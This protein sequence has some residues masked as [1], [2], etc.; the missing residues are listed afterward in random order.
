MPRRI[1]VLEDDHFQRAALIEV[2]QERLARSG[3]VKV[4]EANS[5]SAAY[6]ELDRALRQRWFFDAYILDRIVPWSQEDVIPDR[7]ERVRAEGSQ[8]AGFR[9]AERI[10]EVRSQLARPGQPRRDPPIV[11]YTINDDEFSRS[12]HRPDDRCFT[13]IKREVDP[14]GVELERILTR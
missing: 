9:V 4:T 8:L 10:K 12:F 11:L 14:D 6:G 13:F 5:E 7:P 3:G 1:L 2:L